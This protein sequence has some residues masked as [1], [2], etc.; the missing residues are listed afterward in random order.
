M[1]YSDYIS[2]KKLK[3]SSKDKNN[4]EKKTGSFHSKKKQIYHIQNTIIL[5]EDNERI[6]TNLFHIPLKKIHFSKK[7]NKDEK[8]MFSIPRIHIPEYVKN[9]YEAPFCWTC[10]TPIDDILNG[11]ACSTCDKVQPI[12]FELKEEYDMYLDR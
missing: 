5:D 6:N 9:R 8:P 10:D 11:I 7:K 4:N 1:S 12:M 3:N 2:L